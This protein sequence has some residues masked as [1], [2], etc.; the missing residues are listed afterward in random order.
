MTGGYIAGC[1]RRGREGDELSISHLLF[2]D[3]T[4][5]FCEAS[6]DQQLCLRGI[7]FS[8]EASSGMRINLDKSE[9]ILV[10]EVG[11]VE[12]LAVEL[13][14]WVGSLPFTYLSLPL[15]TSYKSIVV[16]DIIEEKMQKRLATW[17]RSCISKG[18]RV[19]LI[20]STMASMTLYQMSLLR[21]PKVVANR[22]ERL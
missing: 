7:L 6:K 5:L 10:G 15:G 8:F 17:K 12:G 1:H 4:I 20:K 2:A 19:T 11:N 3:D 21:I 16:W 22:M 13:D 18:G 9:L 14:C